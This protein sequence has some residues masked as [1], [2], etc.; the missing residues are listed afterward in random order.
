M[1]NIGTKIEVTIEETRTDEQF[2]WDIPQRLRL[3]CHGDGVHVDGV[4]TTERIVEI[5]K[6]PRG[7]DSFYHYYR[8]LA[9]YQASIEIDGQ[10]DEVAG[11]TLHE[12]MLL[13]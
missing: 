5:L 13:E 2:G 7:E 11:E 8:F 12:F 4:L 1:E 3:T 10:K 6:L 9:T